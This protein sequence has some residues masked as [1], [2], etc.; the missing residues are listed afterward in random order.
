MH[1]IRFHMVKFVFD[2]PLQSWCIPWNRERVFKQ[3]VNSTLSP[4]TVHLLSA[5]CLPTYDLLTF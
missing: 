1:P 5:P 4:R 2:A 3:A